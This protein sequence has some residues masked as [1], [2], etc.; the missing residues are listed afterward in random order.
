MNVSTIDS[1]ST[2]ELRRRTRGNCSR[3]LQK[4]GTPQTEI[5][6]SNCRTLCFNGDCAALPDYGDGGLKILVPGCWTAMH[7]AESER[8]ELSSHQPLT[9]NDALMSVQNVIN[10]GCSCYCKAYE[11]DP[12]SFLVVPMKFSLASSPG[13]GEAWV[14]K[15]YKSHNLMFTYAYPQ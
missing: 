12:P 11:S 3:M 15:S 8:K 2:G 13:N 1:S 14:C 5:I 7:D 9:S 4:T 6:F 10:W